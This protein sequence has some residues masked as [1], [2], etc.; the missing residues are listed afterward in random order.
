MAGTTTGKAR[1]MRD[2][3]PDPCILPD[4]GKYSRKKSARIPWVWKQGEE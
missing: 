1:V 4:P 2:I 3:P